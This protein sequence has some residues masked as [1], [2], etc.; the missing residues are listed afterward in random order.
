[1][2]NVNI[3]SAL[4]TPSVIDGSWVPDLADY[5][6]V[7]ADGTVYTFHLN[8][9]ATWH[10]GR[11]VTAHDCVFTLNAVLDESGLSGLQSSVAS[12]VRSY[13]AIDDH[14]FELVAQ[15]PVAVLFDKSIGGISIVPKHIWE[16]IPF[17][18]W[19]AAPGATGAD[20]SQ[21]SARVRSG[22]ANVCART[23]FRSFAMTTTGYLTSCQR[24]T[25]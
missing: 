12:V 3:F 9:D 14:T 10:D 19:G 13:R 21:V 25:G 8:P 2:M 23:M 17:S 1:M 22:S 6:E 18:D 11:P 4:A 20:P 24:S 5:W 15:R 7:S 16:P